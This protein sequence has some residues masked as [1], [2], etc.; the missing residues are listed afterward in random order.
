M[1]VI[2]D[3]LF[4]TAPPTVDLNAPVVGWRNSLTTSNVSAD[5]SDVNFPVTNVAN[6]ST[7]LKWKSTSL[8]IQHL[9]V[10]LGTPTAIDYFAVAGHNF[11][12]GHVAASVEGAA[13]IDTLQKVMLH[14]DGADAATAIVDSNVGGSAHV[15]TA[16]GNAQLDTA[17][18]K[19]GTAAALF[20]G[21]GD[22]FSSPDHVDFELGGGNWT[23]DCWF[24]CTATSGSTRAIVGKGDAG[25]TAAGSSY[26][27][28]RE[29]TNVMKL[30]VSNGTALATI[31]GTTQ[32]TNLLNPGWHH[33]AAVRVGNI[34]RMF[35]D[36]VQEGGDFAFTGSVAD[37]A[38]ALL[39]GE[40]DEPGADPWQGSIDEFR[41]VVGRAA[42]IANFTPD[43][44]PYDQFDWQPLGDEQMPG[45]DQPIVWRF[46]QATLMAVRLRMRPVSVLPEIAVA[47]TNVL[48]KLQR[49]IYVGYRVLDYNRRSNVVTGFSDEATFLGRLVL[50]ELKESS[51]SLQNITAA[52]F[53]SDVDPWLKNSVERPFFFAWRPTS[54]PLEVGFCW[55]TGDSQMSNQR[56]N[57]MVQ[58]SVGLRGIT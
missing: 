17:I 27:I 32:F 55:I 1:I 33:I 7:Y 45:D 23:I 29:A 34:L 41:V 43:G 56:P 16:N 40:R 39:I 26:L 42:W 46:T 50:G 58:V 51:L 22:F 24:N 13:T 25:F 10:A 44:G 35:I 15:W 20:D 54:Y 38:Q 8:L 4:L 3:D 36:G 9:T 28:R 18:V 47:Y 57:G 30:F 52:F 37:V 12:T 11:G 53:R 48:L 5:F 49:R 31:T 19:F 6:P 14:F 2:S 21:T